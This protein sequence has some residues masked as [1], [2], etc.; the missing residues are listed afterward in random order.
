MEICLCDLQT[1]SAEV[2][3]GQWGMTNRWNQK[4]L[5]ISQ[6]I[7]MEV[8]KADVKWNS[9]KPVKQKQIPLFPETCFNTLSL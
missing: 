9:F 5:H 1:M 4:D 3:F 8:E 7:A 6:G 2:G